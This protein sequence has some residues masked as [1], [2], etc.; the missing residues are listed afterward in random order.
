MNEQEKCNAAIDDVIKDLQKLY[1]KLSKK[2]ILKNIE[3]ELSGTRFLHMSYSGN[4]DDPLNSYYKKIEKKFNKYIK[5]YN[6]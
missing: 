4:Y 3:Y 1:P 5:K 2:C 6:K